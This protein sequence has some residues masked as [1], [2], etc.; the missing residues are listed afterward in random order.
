M[1]ELLIVCI[2]VYIFI[3][4]TVAGLAMLRF[5]M[6][7]LPGDAAAHARAFV[8]SW[9]W[10]WLLISSITKLVRYYRKSKEPEPQRDP[11]KEAALW[12]TGNY[13]TLTKG[14]LDA[15]NK[16]RGKK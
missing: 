8:L 12:E 4:L 9:A 14:Q 13:V 10:P 2:F 1:I 11:A 6:A 3:A 16:A 15:F 7:D 5:Y